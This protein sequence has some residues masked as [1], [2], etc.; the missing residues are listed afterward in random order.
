M[1]R[2]H[3]GW[4]TGRAIVLTL[5]LAFAI[6][7]LYWIIITSLKGQKEIFSLPIQYWP[8]QVTLINYL[9]IFQISHFQVYIWNS[10]LVSL[11]ASA[12]VVFISM[13]GGYVLARFSFTGKR[14]VM[15]GFLVTQ[16]I[17]MF[18]GM[19]PLYMMMSKMHI[20]NSL[21][22]LMLIYTVMLIPF[23][24]II[25]S[26]FFQ[27]IPNALEEAAMMDGCSRLSALFRVIVPIMLPGIA[28]TFIFAFVQC[29]NELIM[30]VLFIDEEPVKT[31]PVA[32]NA[33]IK[34][35][36]I[37]WGAMSA[38]T[39]LSVIPTMLLFAF[40]QKYLVEGLTQGAVKG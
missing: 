2:E 27:R 25:M 12:M 11:V 19:A 36:D 6:F 16:M 38:A 8:E 20:L 29:W 40:C 34:K 18:I 35:Y 39:V 26:G 13:L 5:F 24:T 33:F 21:F 37:E 32:M 1:H 9:E 10:F 23:C 15:F 4:R 14:Q 3:L 28:A 17:P 31:I 30:A 7:P 22:S